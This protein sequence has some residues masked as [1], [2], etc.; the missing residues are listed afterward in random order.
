[1][2]RDLNVIV[3][4]PKWLFSYQLLN[5]NT[6]VLIFY[7]NGALLGQRHFGLR[8]IAYWPDNLPTCI[9]KI[10]VQLFHK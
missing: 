8:Y 10:F 1:M 4:E 2:E 5:G 9:L 7:S 6:I 3:V